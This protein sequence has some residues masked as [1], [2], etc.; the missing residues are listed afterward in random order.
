VVRLCL[1][2]VLVQ[3]AGKGEDFDSGTVV[4]RVYSS[5]VLWCRSAVRLVIRYVPYV[6][7]L[8]RDSNGLHGEVRVPRLANAE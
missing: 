7:S 1:V 4:G 6:S 8:P 2:D 3:Q 5:M